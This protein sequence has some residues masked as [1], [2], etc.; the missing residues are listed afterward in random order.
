MVIRYDSEIGHRYVPEINARIPNELGGYYVRTNAEGFRSDVEFVRER[1]DGSRIVFLGDSVTAGDC[2]S[3]EERFSDLVGKALGAEIYN[4]AL[5]GSGTDQQLLIYERH[6]REV[7]AD[8]IVVPIFIENIERI[9]VGHRETILG[10]TGDRVMV[11]KPYFLLDDE[12]ELDLRHVPVPL[13]RPVAPAE[14]A[15]SR[16]ATS[17][18]PQRTLWRMRQSERLGRMRWLGSR[19]GDVRSWALRLADFQPYPDYSDPESQGWQLMQAILQRLFEASGPIPRCSS[20]RC[21]R[22]PSTGPCRYD[23]GS[24]SVSSRSPIPTTVSTSWTSPPRC[25]RSPRRPGIGSTSSTI[26][27]RLRSVTR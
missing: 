7:E 26:G 19:F 21:R 23:R 20:C 11:P 24:R 5:S 2:V 13:E 22:R 9:K 3:N 15:A 27:T 1:R 12:G 10:S 17:S 16:G 14:P 4:Y 8:L 25:G 18:F 6:A